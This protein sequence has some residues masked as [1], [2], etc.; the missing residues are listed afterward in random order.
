MIDLKDSTERTKIIERIKNILARANGTPYEGEAQT[1]LK[2]AQDHMTK[3]GL[4]ITDIELS[5]ELENEIV[6]VIVDDHASHKCVER[7]ELKLAY[8]VGEVFD[9]QAFRSVRSLY[10]GRTTK[11]KFVGYKQDVEMATIVFKTLYVSCRASACRLF[12]GGE[13]RVRLSFMYGVAER[14]HERAKLEKTV[15]IEKEPTGRYGLVVSEKASRIS[16]WV[17]KSMNV[18][19]KRVSRVSFDFE[20]YRI[21]KA[22]ANSIDLFNKKKVVK[23]EPALAL[24]QKGN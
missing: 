18:T 12:P 15:S 1:A 8:A 11:I 3:Y 9:V 16:C 21:G 5:K 23:K 17:K 13:G 19:E 6:S 7:W 14:L 10:S 22:H 20:A 24:V 2:I 4:S